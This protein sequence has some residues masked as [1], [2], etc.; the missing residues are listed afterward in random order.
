MR[1]E[2][3]A[4]L[5]L[6]LFAAGGSWAAP[7]QYDRLA[8]PADELFEAAVGFVQG[9]DYA[10][11]TKTLQL[12]RPLLASVRA[13]TGEDSGADLESAIALKDGNWARASL[14]RLIYLDLRLN[15]EAASTAGSQDAAREFLLPA[16]IDY[17]FL[18]PVISAQDK[19][20][21]L[22]FRSAMRLAYRSGEPASA[23]DAL[24]T[25][26]SLSHLF[27][28][29]GDLVA[30]LSSDLPTYREAYD[31][32]RGAWPTPVPILALDN[33][34]P[35]LA[36]GTRI[37]VAFGAKAAAQR[38][39]PGVPLVYCVA[40]GSVVGREGTTIMIDMAPEASVLLG[41]LLQIHP[42]LKRIGVVWLSAA[43]AGNVA[44]FK[45]AGADASVEVFAE[46]LED[47]NALPGRLRELKRDQVDGLWL[48]ADSQVL[49]PY[50]FEILRD[51]SYANG[52]PL[53]APTENLVERGATASVS[54]SYQELGRAAA[55]AAKS[56]LADRKQPA[57]LYVG[58]A[59]ISVNLA[60]AK[61]SSLSIPDAVLKKA[62]RVFTK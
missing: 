27:V 51:Y 39:P 43:L 6:A 23:R 40:P 3:P 22:T 21:G 15:L 16:S 48:P 24:K 9:G 57:D 46:P 60:A 2:L 7:T 30:V 11:L 17:A 13:R 45:R 28:K 58:S 50:N 26:R 20:A 4:M 31:G 52:I 1:R 59:E 36:D 19:A 41:K 25:L 47:A 44:A 53:F 42:G 55:D 61:E 56:A 14:Y 18:A 29:T 54:V 5:A 62:A 34:G 32:L 37:V 10:N 35:A 33:G 12:L 8:L 49:T 38:Y